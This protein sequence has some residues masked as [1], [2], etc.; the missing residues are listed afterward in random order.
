VQRVSPCAGAVA[1]PRQGIFLGC[2]DAARS[3]PQSRRPGRRPYRQL[4]VVGQW[5]ARTYA[6][7]PTPGRFVVPAIADVSV[8]RGYRPVLDRAAALSVFDLLPAVTAGLR[9]D[10]RATRWAIWRALADFLGA[11]GVAVV[12]Q[13]RLAQRASGYAGRRVARSTAGNHLRALEAAGVLV[14]A[15]R[16]ASRVALGTDRDRAPAY[17]IVAPQEP[18]PAGELAVPEDDEPVAVEELGHLPK[19]STP[20]H[21]ERT[22]SL[23]L[24]GHFSPPKPLVDDRDTNH[25][26]YPVLGQLAEETRPGPTRREH[27]ERYTARTPAEWTLAVAWLSARMGWAYTTRTARELHTITAPWLRAGWTPAAVLHA[28]HHRPDGTPWP[29]PLP[30]PHHRDR[31]DRLRIRNRWAVLTYRLAAW[32]DPLGQPSTPPIPAQP[33]R[34][35]RPPTPPTPPVAPPAAR[36]TPPPRPPPNSPRFAPTGPRGRPT[37]PGPQPSGKHNTNN[38]GQDNKTELRCTRPPNPVIRGRRRSPRAGPQAI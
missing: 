22:T 5:Q 13:Q 28:W 14:V 21:A 23:P 20:T 37:T 1:D 16:G 6:A 32:R 36:S 7:R 35:G 18:G 19:G 3:R 12:G 8:P 30:E 27:P 26:A 25:T 24:D 10:S 31:R 29:G 38:S 33:P 15:I 2:S 34:R 11:T 17:V 4:S 9:E